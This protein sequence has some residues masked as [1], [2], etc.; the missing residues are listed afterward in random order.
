MQLTKN[1]AGKDAQ[2]VQKQLKT[3]PERA[4]FGR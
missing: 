1:N 3:R 2:K 4:T